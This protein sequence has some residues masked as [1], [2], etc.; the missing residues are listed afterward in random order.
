M[1]FMLLFGEDSGRERRGVCTT[2]RF[3]ANVS[4]RARRYLPCLGAYEAD[5]SRAI[6][7]IEE[8]PLSLATT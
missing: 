6:P 8:A 3:S 4:P 7:G 2:E 5:H 1:K